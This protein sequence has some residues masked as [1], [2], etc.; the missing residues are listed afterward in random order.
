MDEWTV[1]VPES[2][3]DEWPVYPSLVWMSGLCT[4]RA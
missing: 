1:R 2:C 4:V 3:V